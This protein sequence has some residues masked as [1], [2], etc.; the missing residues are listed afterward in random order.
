M[1]NNHMLECECY[2]LNFQKRSNSVFTLRINIDIFNIIPRILNHIIF[3]LN[4]KNIAKKC[5][6]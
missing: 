6:Q 5:F 3:Q 4:K 1:Y 2:H